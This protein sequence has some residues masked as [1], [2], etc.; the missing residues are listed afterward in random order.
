MGNIK[1]AAKVRAVQLFPVNDSNAAVAAF[2][3]DLGRLSGAG[4]DT[5]RRNCRN[6]GII[7]SQKRKLNLFINNQT[8]KILAQKMLNS[9]YS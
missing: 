4:P 1:T 3:Y 2:W 6:A 8:N 9:A 7:Y 5:A